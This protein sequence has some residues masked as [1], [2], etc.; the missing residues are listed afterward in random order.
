MQSNVKV[1]NVTIEEVSLGDKYLTKQ[2]NTSN[3]YSVSSV[4]LSHTD[5]RYLTRTLY[6]I[7]M[8]NKVITLKVLVVPSDL[9]KDNED[10]KDS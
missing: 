6:P 8:T 10:D 7:R 9:N 5:R 1:L 4:H 3:F 2:W